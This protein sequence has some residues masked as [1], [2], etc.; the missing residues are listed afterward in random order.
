VLILAP[1]EENATRYS[2]VTKSVGGEAA[3]GRKKGGDN[4]DW[5]D[6]NLTRPKNEE[7]TCGRFNCYK[8]TVNI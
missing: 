7:N 4:T 2:D 1:L 3:P 8:W 6:V 5:V